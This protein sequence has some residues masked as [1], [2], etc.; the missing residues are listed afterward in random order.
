MR[1]IKISLFLFILPF[2]LSAQLR[3]EIM[4]SGKW[5]FFK[6]GSMESSNI[7]YVSFPH[8]W[9]DKDG[10]SSDYYRGEGSY[11]YS[12]R[13]GKKVGKNRVFLRFGAVSQEADV[14]LNGHYIGNHKGGFTAF[15]FEITPYIKGGK[16]NVLTVI[17]NNLSERNKYIK[18]IYIDEKKY[19]SSFINYFDLINARTIRFV[20]SDKP[21]MP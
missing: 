14:F 17:A 6:G 13:L 11:S 10:T 1:R 2:F 7:E 9:N 19:D 21:A 5:R 3:E 18:D 12:F 20:M 16:E 8:T 15:C 4:L